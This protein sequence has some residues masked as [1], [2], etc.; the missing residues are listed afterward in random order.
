MVGIGFA[1]T[2]N[3][4]YLVSAADSGDLPTTFVM[5]CVASPFAHPLFTT[6]TGIGVGIAVGSRSVVVRF[7]APV[8][9]YLAAVT[10]H[11]IWNGS[12]IFGARG[13]AAMYVLVMV[14]GFLA[15]VA[16]AVWARSAERRMLLRALRDAAG[17]GLLPATDIGW[18][19]DLGARRRAR[20]HARQ[21]GGR[22][23]VRAMR[24][25][26]QAV[27]ELGYLHHRYLRGTPPADFGRRGQEFV[28]RIGRVRPT[29]AFPGQVVPTR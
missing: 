17:R 25:Y 23:G 2:E 9:G 27:I 6:F 10:A 15:L 18:V 8:L 21:T 1:F 24:D 22:A 4:L 5:R 7:L 11:A 26:Q 3:I 13:Y 29:I 12:V 19:V 28:A 16:L 14:P 20:L